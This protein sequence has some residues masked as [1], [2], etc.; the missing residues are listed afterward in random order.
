MKQVP[1]KLAEHDKMKL[2][3]GKITRA[4]AL[5]ISPEY[6]AFAEHT[7]GFE[8][9]SKNF[10]VVEKEFAKLKKGQAI[11]VYHDGEFF[12]GKVSSINHND[13]RAVDGPIVRVTNGEYSWRVDGAGYCFPM[14]EIVHRHSGDE[15]FCG[16]RKKGRR[17]T[18]DESKVTCPKCLGR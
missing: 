13:F 8:G 1:D 18:T 7:G 10:D 12:E 9:F 15:G 16:S 2:T 4:A 17:F 5:A 14:P 11:I 6:V 3:K